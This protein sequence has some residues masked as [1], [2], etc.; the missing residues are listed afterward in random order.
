MAIKVLPSII[1]SPDQARI[2]FMYV[3]F[4]ANDASL[5]EAPNKQHVSIP[6]Y[7]QNLETIIT[8][9][10][11]VA[12]KP[13]IILVAPPPIN[14]HSIML[15]NPGV[16][17]AR[18]A[19]TTKT[20]AEATCELGEKLGVPVV[21]LWKVF[22]AQTG[23]T[24]SWNPDEPLP[25]SMSVA[26]HD[27]LVELL[28][29]GTVSHNQLLSLILTELRPAFQPCWVCRLLRRAHEGHLGELA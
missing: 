9:P 3:F 5:P 16:E 20:Y 14:E 13:R 29:D 11:V 17:L 2:R 15:T 18:V 26:Q 27:V 4:G 23:W 12:H 1:P 22:M 25:G 10:L 24:D 28:S 6:E 8:H 19:A 21:N 7:K